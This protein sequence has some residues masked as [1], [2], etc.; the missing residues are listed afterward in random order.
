MAVFFLQL[1]VAQFILIARET[2]LNNVT[3]FT[4]LSSLFIALICCVFM[5]C[6]LGDQETN[7]GEAS[8]VEEAVE[9]YPRLPQDRRLCSD[10]SQATRPSALQSTAFFF[11]AAT[12]FSCGHNGYC[13]FHCHRDDDQP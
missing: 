10:L 8:A 5:V 11:L 4:L 6:F 7:R 2:T 12:S 3:M 13:H 1:F 9:E